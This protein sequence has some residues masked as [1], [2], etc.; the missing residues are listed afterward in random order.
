MSLEIVGKIVQFLP[1]VSGEGQNG[2]WKKREVIIE[3]L[4][5]YP[6]KIALSCWN[7]RVDDINKIKEGATIKAYISI[8]SREYN[9][10][11]YTDVRAW[12]LEAS[13][14]TSSGPNSQPNE[15]H[16]AM[17]NTSSMDDDHSANSDNGSEGDDLPF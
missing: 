15:A 11:W 2:P 5:Q 3:T 9:E 17:N 1:E 12:R 14:L 7:E 13:D 6:K 4:E 16:E 10:R 8:S